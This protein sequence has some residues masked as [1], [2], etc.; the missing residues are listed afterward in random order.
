MGLDAYVDAA[1]LSV[2]IG[3]Y[4]W[5]HSF[6]STVCEKLEGGDWGSRFP[7]LM[8][9][10]DCDGT[11]TPEEAGELLDELRTIKKEFESESVMYPVALY[12]DGDGKVIDYREKY[13]EAGTFVYGNGFSF[14]ITEDGLVVEADDPTKI[15]LPVDEIRQNIFGQPRYRWYFDRMER[16][17]NDMW[18]CRRRD[19]NA[20][21]VKGVPTCAPPG[22]VLIKA[23]ELPAVEL[24]KDIIDTLEELCRASVETG[25]PIVFC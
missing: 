11:Y 15:G 23:G 7:K 4:G 1:D 18:V 19:G 6:R 21:T 17:G 2:K 9:H 3:S 16:A 14:G 22:C 25:D 5:Y 12:C 8:N 20:V 24:F 13:S 10:S